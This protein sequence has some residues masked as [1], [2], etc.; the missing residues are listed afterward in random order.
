MF[1]YQ[2]VNRKFSDTTIHAPPL[3]VYSLGS[4]PLVH[5]GSS[6]TDLKIKVQIFSHVH[7]Q[8]PLQVATAGT[9]RF[10]GM[11]IYIYILHGPYIDI[12]QVPAPESQ[13]IFFPK[14]QATSHIFSGLIIKT[15]Q[16]YK[17]TYPLVN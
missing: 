5:H 3:L 10:W 8:L 1:I 2:R 17:P 12:L 13:N 7:V 9:E 4:P 11:Y 15:Y 14:R 16:N 6:T